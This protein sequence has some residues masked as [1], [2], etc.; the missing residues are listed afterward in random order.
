M[1]LPKYIT[2]LNRQRM[3]PVLTPIAELVIKTFEFS[4]EKEIQY[5]GRVEF[6]WFNRQNNPMIFLEI[7][8]PANITSEEETRLVDAL[9][10]E[11]DGQ[12]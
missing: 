9:K 3:K 11:F 6:R 8:T 5:E 2:L 4:I 7:D 1:L 10:R 12:E